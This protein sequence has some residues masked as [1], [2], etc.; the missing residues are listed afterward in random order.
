MRVVGRVKSNNATAAATICSAAGFAAELLLCLRAGAY[1]AVGPDRSVMM[2]YRKRGRWSW[3]R[4]PEVD[5]RVA[6]DFRR[7]KGFL[8]WLL[9]AHPA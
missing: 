5:P 2:I 7:V 4:H 6:A 1:A 8:P 3:T 9:A